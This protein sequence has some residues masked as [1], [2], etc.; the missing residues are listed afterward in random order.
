MT[1]SVAERVTALSLSFALLLAL[2]GAPA[3]AGVPSPVPTGGVPCDPMLRSVWRIVPPPLACQHRFRA[4]GALDELRV[5]LT[6]RDCFDVPV[7]RCAVQATLAPTAQTAAFCACES[8]E[9]VAETNPFGAVAFAFRRIGGRGS[10]EVRLTL[11]CSGNIG[12]PPLGF[13]FTSPDL[14]GSCEPGSATTIL[15][16]GLWAAGLQSYRRVSD[17][18]CDGLVNVV[19][20][21]VWAGG[22]GHG[23]P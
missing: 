3:S 11:L 13:D 9:Q 18:N 17:Y 15:D 23:C 5:L 4:D 14:S 2:S 10:A 16:L 20:L 8:I 6:L 12:F 21:G 22:L 1:A 7:D 19:D